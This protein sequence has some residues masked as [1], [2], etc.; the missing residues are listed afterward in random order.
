MCKKS[1]FAIRMVTV[2]L[3]I[4]M[5]ITAVC[6]RGFSCMNREN[7][8]L[9]KRL[10]KDTPLTILCALILMAHLQLILILKN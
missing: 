10:G 2:L 7:S 8:L 4:M 1:L 9:R 5:T 3:E 6:E